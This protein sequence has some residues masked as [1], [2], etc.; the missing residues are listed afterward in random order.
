VRR[1]SD[2]P[3]E[4]ARA[5]LFACCGSSRWV[6]RMLSQRPFKDR[7]EVFASATRIWRDIGREDWLEAFRAHPKIGERKAAAFRQSQIGRNLRVLTLHLSEAHSATRTPA[8]STNYLRLLVDGVY[9]ANQ[10]LDVK[11]SGCV[12]NSLLGQ[13]SASDFAPASLQ[14]S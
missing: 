13:A 3:E 1:I 11:P 6:E 12:V 8:L 14:M 5:E 2:L 9:T 4:E 7:D 10:W